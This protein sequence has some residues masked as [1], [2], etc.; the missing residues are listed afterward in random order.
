MKRIFLICAFISAC[1]IPGIKGQESP[2]EKG[3]AAIS[4]DIIKAQLGFLASDWTE[5]REAGEKGEF[6]AG[7]YIA[8]MLQLFGVKPGGDMQ[9]GGRSYF[10]NFSLLKTLPGDIHELNLKSQIG[11]S[12][13]KTEFD[14]NVDFVFRS[15]VN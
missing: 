4:E 9:R 8:S 3:M 14:Y 12:I 1:F 11:N 7:D 5:G 10:Q 15:V 13:R 6:I 2:V